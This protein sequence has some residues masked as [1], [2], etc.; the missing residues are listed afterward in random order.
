MPHALLTS[1]ILAVALA[2]TAHAQ[3]LEPLRGGGA[4]ASCNTS[5]AILPPPGM[6]QPSVVPFYLWGDMAKIWTFQRVNQKKLIEDRLAA[7]RM[8]DI[9]VSLPAV[10]PLPLPIA[11]CSFNAIPQTKQLRLTFRA[12]GNAMSALLRRPL[13]GPKVDVRV[14]GTFDLIV[15]M[16][17]GTN[18]PPGK[19]LVLQRAEMNVF[20]FRF[21]AFNR[22]DARE[23]GRTFARQV[24]SDG[25]FATLVGIDINNILRSH[26]GRQAMGP[27]TPGAR[28]GG[29]ETRL[30]FDVRLVRPVLGPGVVQ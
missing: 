1:L 13:F 11:G 26:V 8:R 27:V 2:T 22:P 14:A 15:V 30:Y 29:D 12:R 20:D 4:S 6:A 24:F 10:P 5:V 25:G 28:G 21:T 3:A 18:G 23:A 17:F 16:F 7:M 9:A 19:P